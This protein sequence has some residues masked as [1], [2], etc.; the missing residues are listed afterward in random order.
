MEETKDVIVENR[1]LEKL[2]LEL[3]MKNNYTYIEIVE[4]LSKIRSNSG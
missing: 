2:L 1:T 4:K 3:R